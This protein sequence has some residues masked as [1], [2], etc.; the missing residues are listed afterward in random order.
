MLWEQ[1]CED[2][3]TTGA[4]DAQEDP[5]MVFLESSPRP[6]DA[7]PLGVENTCWERSGAVGTTDPGTAGNSP[8]SLWTDG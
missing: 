1:A 6:A 3:G 8:S 4:G 7:G 5:E 2:M